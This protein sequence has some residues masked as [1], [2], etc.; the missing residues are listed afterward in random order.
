MG[1]CAPGKRSL[2]SSNTKPA[3]QAGPALEPGKLGEHVPDPD[4]GSGSWWQPLICS[5]G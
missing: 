3:G 5:L 4:Q 1:K 2:V